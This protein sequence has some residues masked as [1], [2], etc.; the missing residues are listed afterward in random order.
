[1]SQHVFSIKSNLIVFAILMGLLVLTVVVALAFDLGIFEIPIAL[2][3]AMIKAMVIMLYFMHLRYS[4]QL[5]W[6]FAGS[7]TL[8][9]VILIAFTLSDFETTGE[10]H[11]GGAPEHGDSAH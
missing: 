9:L 4:S 7:G 6:L 2:T 3:I 5:T 1:M 10:A 11:H 8:F